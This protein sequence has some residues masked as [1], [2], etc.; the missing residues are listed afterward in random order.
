[1]N[2]VELVLPEHWAP[3][4]VNDDWTGLNDDE[5]YELKDAIDSLFPD[6]FSS[7][8]VEDSVAQFEKYH[9]AQRYGVLPCDCIVYGFLF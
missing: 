4:L 3:A 2:Y 8:C 7:V 9:D 6:G 1:M 5:E